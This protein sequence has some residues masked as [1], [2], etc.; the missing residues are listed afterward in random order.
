MSLSK[1]LMTMLSIAIL[2]IIA[3]FTIGL[4]KMDNVYEE[5]NRCNIDSLPSILILNDMQENFYS[6]EGSCMGARC[7]FRIKRR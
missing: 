4:S 5:T 2:G 7:Q 6:M 3:V 1:Q